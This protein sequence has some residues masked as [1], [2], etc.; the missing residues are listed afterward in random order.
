MKKLFFILIQLLMPSL[1]LADGGRETINGLVFDC[2]DQY[3]TG[4]CRFTADFEGSASTYSGKIVIPSTV[5][6]GGN[7]YTVTRIGSNVFMN[8]NV[9]SVYIPSTITAFDS[10]AFY[11]GKSITSIISELTNPITISDELMFSGINNSC[12]LVVPQGCKSAYASKN[13]STYIKGGTYENAWIK[14][15]DKT[16][17]YGDANPTL[18]YSYA[19]L[20]T[21][22]GIP[23][24]SCSATRESAIGNYQI[25]INNKADLV[26]S[27]IATFV[28]GTLSVTKAPLTATAKSYTIT[29]GE[30]LPSYEVQYNGFKNSETSSVL[31][32][33][34]IASCAVTSSSG[35]G[36]YP[37]TVSGG[38]AAN[39]S[40]TYVS[41][42]LTITAKNASNL[43]INDISGVTYNGLAQTPAIIVKDGTKTLTSGTDYTVVYSNNTNVGTASVT[44]TGIGKYTGTKTANFTIERAPLTVT[45]KSYTIT[46]GD[47][48]PTFEATY[49]GFQN[50]ETSS[51]L[52]TQP[53]FSCI[54]TSSSNTGSFDINVSGA[55]ADNY[56][57]TYV[58]GTLT[59]NTNIPTLAAVDLGLPSGKLWANMNVGANAIED[60]GDSFAWGE[61]EIKAEYTKDNYI[62]GTT[63]TIMAKYNSEDGLTIL[64]PTDD[65]ATVNCGSEWRTPTLEEWNELESNCTRTW[66]TIN[67]VTGY[68]FVSTNNGNE[69]F[70]PCGFD[71]FWHKGAGYYW[72]ATLNETREYA[73][74]DVDFDNGGF[75]IDSTD[76]DDADHRRVNRNIRPIYDSSRSIYGCLIVTGTGFS[77]NIDIDGNTTTA[78]ELTTSVTGNVTLSRPFTKDVKATICLPFDVSAAKASELGHFYQFSGLKAG[79]TDVVQ[80]TEVTTGLTAGTAYVFEPSATITSIDFGSL[81]ITANPT[82]AAANGDFAF[83]GTYS[84]KTWT[85][86]DTEIAN[87]VYGFALSGVAGFTGGQFV[88]LGSGAKVRPFRCYLKYNGS[89]TGVATT[90]SNHESLPD[91]FAIE[92]I[93]ARGTTNI[94]GI[95]TIAPQKEEWYMLD[96]HKLSG[97]P[98]KKGVYIN[99]GRKVVIK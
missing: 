17:V 44:I 32:T 25:S 60:S 28:D 14:A 6:Y 9:T 40:F 42:T 19:S 79:T 30:S 68:K 16:K 62:Y 53:S 48:L 26:S 22:V 75:Y 27:R 56:N 82:P 2:F 45:A 94:S 73:A 81:T 38:S 23:T 92:W 15:D 8:S 21:L 71:N 78:L 70:L 86:G 72:T 58:K 50:G 59:I 10:N 34:P 37:I 74:Y 18:T 35:P 41:G 65:A 1:A 96:G 24:M 52:T 61:T 29:Y 33:A 95:K 69:I 80:M 66:T 13:W 93:S 31:T 91:T 99:N 20:E 83:Q 7:T 63:E 47:A 98:V 49:S 84:Y 77:Q 51:V 11:G 89:L 36:T 85:E 87:G 54:A 97:M 39:Y 55:D 57:F 43:T 88:K 67:G 76:P 4:T 5:N 90:R 46:Q 3:G 64:K 12:V